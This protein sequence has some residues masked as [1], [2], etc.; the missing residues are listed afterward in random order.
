MIGG[1]IGG[2]RRGRGL[3]AVFCGMS[4][5]ALTLCALCLAPLSPAAAGEAASDWAASDQGRVRL[6]AATS[7]A[8]DAAMPRLGLEFDLAPG[9]KIYWRSPEGAGYPPA[10]DWSG[11][12]NLAATEIA[13]P[14]PHRAKPTIVRSGEDATE[15][16]LAVGEGGAVENLLT[17]AIRVTIVDGE[18]SI[19]Q[20]VVVAAAASQRDLD[21]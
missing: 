5:A 6:I 16:C 1:M 21:G 14:A 10:V 19:E 13:W 12:S 4:A 20:E 17:R 8:A 7:S 9:W 15:L 11:S 18:R 3:L 2:G